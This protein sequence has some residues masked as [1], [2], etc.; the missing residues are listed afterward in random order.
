MSFTYD[1]TLATQLSWVR[2][3]ANDTVS[4]RAKF[5]DEELTALLAQQES[6]G[7]TGEAQRLLAAADALDL[8]ACKAGGAQKEKRLGPLSVSLQGGDA[9]YS[10]NLSRS[11]R[12][13]AADLLSAAGGDSPY[14]RCL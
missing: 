6:L 5:Q 1:P 2:F 13:R 14:L 3:L 11:Y 4:S 9:E 10:G 12:V 8:Y 7:Y